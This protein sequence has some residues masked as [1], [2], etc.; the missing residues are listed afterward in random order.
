MEEPR[1]RRARDGDRA[2]GS[3]PGLALRAMLVAVQ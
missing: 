2:V 3:E 1:S